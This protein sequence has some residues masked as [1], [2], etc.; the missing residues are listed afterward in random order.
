ME[1]LEKVKILEDKQAI[2]ELTHNYLAAAD[3]KDHGAM[4]A[5]FTSNGVLTSVIDEQTVVLHG[6]TEISNGFVR[7]LAPINTAYHLVGQLLIDLNGN[8]AKGTSY[9]FVTLVGT[10]SNQKYVR[11]IWAVYKDEYVKEND[12]WLINNR[13]ATVAWEEKEFY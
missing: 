7:I 9:S 1:T 11:K 13:V 8:T 5:H 4:A 12:Q 10:E 3:R 2:Q 6:T